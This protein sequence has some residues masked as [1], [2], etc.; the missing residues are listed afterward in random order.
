MHLVRFDRSAASPFDPAG[1]S[2]SESW[3]AVKT[4]R[5]NTVKESN[6]RH[7]GIDRIDALLLVYILI[8][9]IYTY[10]GV[11]VIISLQHL[12]LLVSSKTFLEVEVLCCC[13]SCCGCIV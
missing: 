10:D 11:V 5:E 1:A 6:A 3:L 12:R 9:L 8:L 13:C 4:E 7:D 2:F